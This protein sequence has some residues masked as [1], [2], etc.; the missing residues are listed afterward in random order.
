MSHIP[1]PPSARCYR[2]C[3]LLLL[4]IHAGLLA[5]SGLVHSPTV[6]EIAHLASGISHWKFGR[7]ELYSVNPPLVRTVAAGPV[8]FSCDPELDW[9]AYR[10]DPQARSEVI[11]GRRFAEI[12]GA[13][14]CPML[15]VARWACIPFSLLGAALCFVW[16]RELYS[17][18]AGLLAASLWCFS[19]FM[20]GHGALITAD[21]PAASLGL[22]A[23][24]SFRRWLR[25]VGPESALLAGAVLGAA[26]LTK[27]T[28][29]VL[30]G[31]WPLLWLL[32]RGRAW[33]TIWQIVRE[34]AA[35]GAILII[36]L[37]VVNAF[38]GFR[39]AFTRL[40]AFEFCSESLA[41][42]LDERDSLRGNRFAGSL[43]ASV[44]MP[45]PANYLQGIDIQKRD[46]EFG[47][48][49]TAWSPYL[50]GEWRAG[51]WWYFYFVA[52]AAKEPL[53]LWVLFVFA[54]LSATARWCGNPG[55]RPAGGDPPKRRRFWK[56]MVAS[57]GIAC[58]ADGGTSGRGS[59]SPIAGAA[60]LAACS[61]H[62]DRLLLAAGA[63]TVLGLV[64]AN[65]GLCNGRY[66]IPALP[67]LYIFCGQAACLVTKLY[68]IRSITVAL[69][70]LAFVAS[71]VR[72]FPHS[73]SYINEIF[74]GP[75][76]NDEIFADS[77]IDWG[78]DL[79]FLEEWLQSHPEIRQL[80]LAYF[81]SLHPHNIGMDFR[82]PPYRKQ[83]FDPYSPFRAARANE[84][85]QWYAVSR[86]FLRGKRYR[87]PDGSGDFQP[88]DEPAFTY[89]LQFEP[90]ETVGYS[91][92]LYHLTPTEVYRA[93]YLTSAGTARSGR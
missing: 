77:D 67:F 18:R 48:T 37:A 52:L 21:V 38:Y 60:G 81:G 45:L 15:T 84:E 43:L 65:T 42:P 1:R 47:R 73:L 51:G 39:G 30:L 17:P 19:P 7:F 83:D 41:G 13:A 14:V 79:L 58:G 40:G 56:K 25:T 8:L 49:R 57:A 33:R 24:L 50:F 11:V 10:A 82:L 12:N 76:R 46:F 23:F 2:I 35:L 6:D 70:W 80:H 36:G 93:W 75:A 88:L 62:T 85:R 28:W 34:L 71:S 61:R 63:A 86:T 29:I 32:C 72:F 66:A 74:G 89:F 90:T 31:L 91:I 16:A 69:I 68:P 59:P 27:S 5:W 54:S 9:S 53:G 55:R 3:L 22:A 92:N 87:I 44:P 4:G 64:T 26:L 20:L 78:Q